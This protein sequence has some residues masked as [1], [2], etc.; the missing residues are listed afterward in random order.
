MHHVTGYLFILFNLQLLQEVEEE[1][2]AAVDVVVMED[3]EEETSSRGG[4]D[5]PKHCISLYYICFHS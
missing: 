4:D 3:E 2:D 1:E 5:L